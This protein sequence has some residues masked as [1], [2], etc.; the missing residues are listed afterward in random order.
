MVAILPVLLFPKHAVSPDGRAG[1]PLKLR[2][3]F[4]A[5]P[6]AE[7]ALSL[8]G[9]MKFKRSRTKRILRHLGR[10]LL[11]GTITERAKHGFALPVASL[12][13]GHVAEPISDTLFDRS[14]PMADFFVTSEIEKIVSEH[15]NR[16][17]DNR[18]RI[19]SLYCLF[20]FAR[21]T[22]ALQA[23]ARAAN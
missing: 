9:S 15:R 17:R 12:I 2:A 23:A 11:P 21:N 14:N 22:R 8:P 10:R 18:K 5:R 1:K 7:F 16:T 6:L 19:W 13:R 20:L 3:P 4:L